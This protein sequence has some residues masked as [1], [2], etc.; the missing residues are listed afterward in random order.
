MKAKEPVRLRERAIKNGNRS[1]Y[2][3]FYIN[4]ER[5][6]EYLHLYLIPERTKEDKKANEETLSLANAIKSQRIV[7]LQNKVHGFKNTKDMDK[8]Y[9]FDFLEAFLRKRSES[10]AESTTKKIWEIVVNHLHSYEK[11]K[12]IQFRDITSE[13]VRGFVEFL[14]EKGRPH[15]RTKVPLSPNTCNI[16]L[17]KLSCLLKK[18]VK[19]GIL[20]RNPC[21][22]I[23]RPK[24]QP[25][26]RMYITI[27]EL[28]LL[29]RTDCDNQDIKRM[30]LFSCLTGLRMSDVLNLKWKDVT[31]QGDFT[32][33]IFTQQK[34]KRM[35]YLD[36]SYQAAELLGD[37][38]GDEDSCFVHY[39]GQHINNVLRVWV[40]RAGIK[41][42]ITFHCARHTFATM[43]LD[44]GTDIFV[45]SKL[46]GHSNITTTQVYSKVLDKNKQ[47]AVSSIPDILH[48]DEK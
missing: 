44:L 30:F 39:T 12:E 45:V 28:R 11:N 31:A 19:V 8:V 33:I 7:E 9:F 17:S 43:M 4:G 36:I 41:K 13:W 3:D 21:D 14:E 16:Y 10:L 26:Q 5:S 20:D 46:L 47:R 2:L 29:A 18:A 37:R 35:E 22:G 27:D 25:S 34:T 40:A 1:L 23:E 15:H 38:G 24:G 48:V 32:R 6:Y 42:H